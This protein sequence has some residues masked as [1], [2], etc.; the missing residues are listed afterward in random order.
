MPTRMSN[1][2]PTSISIPTGYEDVQRS[3]DS[4]R[5]IAESMLASG[6]A[7]TPN[8]QSILQ[9]LGD[10]ADT[11]AG[12]S[13]GRDA[14]KAQGTLDNQISSDYHT[15][16]SQF[17]QDAQTLQPAD[18]IAKWG[19][20]PM[21]GE[22]LKPYQAALQSGMEDNQKHRVFGGRW[23]RNGD[24]QEGSY[25][26]GKPTDNA[27]RMPDGTWAVNPVSVTGALAR[28]G[29]TA[30]EMNNPVT[31]MPDPYGPNAG[32]MP[33]LPSTQT[34]PASSSSGYQA[35]TVPQYK[36][37]AGAL[38]PGAAADWAARNNIAVHV[39]S[40]QEAMTLPHGTKII[41]PDGSEG[42]VP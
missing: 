27:I 20:D 12:K 1:I 37:A 36:A 29:V 23:M 40:P 4:K 17:S 16:V 38:G 2:K 6:L 8:A 30:G 15:K 13:M 42:K 25:E 5:K 32:Q 19:A 34:P 21:M 26:P 39:T 41:L 18:L 35:L 14:D 7:G 33:S 10:W 28:Q 9:V 31:S 11:W 3:V 22:A 24:I